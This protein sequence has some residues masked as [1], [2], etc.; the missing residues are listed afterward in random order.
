[1]KWEAVFFDF[2]GVICDSANIKTEAFAEMYKPYGSEVQ[3]QV[4]AY[5]LNN[6]GVSR[7][8]KFKYW[9]R[10][11]LNSDINDEQLEALSNNFSELVL[12]KILEASY[13][14][15]ATETLNAL[16]D[17]KITAYIVS[18]TP[19]DEIKYIIREKGLTEF[20]KEVYGSPRKKGDI[21][22]DILSRESF[23]ADKC[24]FIGDAM[25]DYQAAVSN[26]IH[27]LGIAP[28]GKNSIFPEG[29]HISSRVYL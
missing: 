8:E 27:F 28:S 22:K 18:G 7:F 5:H 4:V 1:M 14:E 17:R 16:K 12:K 3:K 23:N 20:F 26:G 19:D 15:G 24:I 6:G 9:H 29:T 21:V 11:H 10:I 13:I 2:D 25:S